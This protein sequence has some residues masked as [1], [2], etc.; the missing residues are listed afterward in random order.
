M[1]GLPAGTRI[2]LAAGVT[3]IRAGMN[4]LATCVATVA[5]E[6]LVSRQAPAPSSS[7]GGI[8]KPGMPA[9]VVLA[10]YTDYLAL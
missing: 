6:N 5:T 10:K 4:G 7:S 2:W 9:H 3:D 8:A 1:I